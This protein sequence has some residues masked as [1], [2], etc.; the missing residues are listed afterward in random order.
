[1][2]S[3]N[4]NNIIIVGCM[5]SYISIFLLG[6]DGGVVPAKYVKYVCAVS[7]FN[8][9][10]YH[11]SSLFN[12]NI[13]TFIHVILNVEKCVNMLCQF[14]YCLYSLHYPPCFYI[15]A[16]TVLGIGDRIFLVIWSHV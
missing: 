10:N 12:I 6:T 2:S 16:G 5:L 14:L 3:P 8:S 15:F 4:M 7:P 13:T 11:T 1:M 9:F